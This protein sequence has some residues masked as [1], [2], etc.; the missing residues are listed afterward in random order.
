MR[1]IQTKKISAMVEELCI[2]AN[3]D[4]NADIEDALNEALK[5][6][7]TPVAKDVLSQLIENAAIARSEQIPICQDT[8]MT[9][10]FADVGQD[11]H[12]TGGSLT[13]AINE[14]VRLGYQNGCLRKSVVADPINRINTNDNT[15]AVIYYDIVAGDGLKITV[16]PKGFGSENMSRIKMLTPADGFDGIRDFVTETVKIAAS[17]P[18]PPVIVGVGVGGTMDKAALLAKRA[19]LRP[20]TEKNSA[21]FWADAENLFLEQINALGIGPAGFGGVVTA[22]KVSIETYPTH[23]AGL[24]VAVNIGCCATRHK[25]GIL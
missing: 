15:P 25:H 10:V 5:T 17:N 14:G 18:C 12:V 3:I 22:L 9:V 19:L 1:E 21:P 8:G 2:S 20:I 13:D 7:K 4:L 16:A 24:P 23:I 11:V 6:E